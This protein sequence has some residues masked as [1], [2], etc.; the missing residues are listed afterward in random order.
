MQ[1][2]KRVCV[3]YVH[4]AVFLRIEEQPII[5]ESQLGVGGSDVRLETQKSID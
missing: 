5:E 3:T 2:N 1:K 4:D